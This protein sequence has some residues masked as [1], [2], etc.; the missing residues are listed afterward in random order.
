MGKL[1]G[2][3]LLLLSLIPLWGFNPA[4]IFPDE[5]IDFIILTGRSFIVCNG[6]RFNLE[7]YTLKVEE[8]NLYTLSLHFSNR[9]PDKVEKFGFLKVKV[10]NH[11]AAVNIRLKLWYRGQ[12]FAFLY[13]GKKPLKVLDFSPKCYLVKENGHLKPSF[14][15]KEEKVNVNGCRMFLYITFTRC[16]F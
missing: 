1:F 16:G 11:P 10:Y 12:R 8:K 15:V 7:T 2:L 13:W 3:I 6:K 9:K 5:K 14:E 4:S